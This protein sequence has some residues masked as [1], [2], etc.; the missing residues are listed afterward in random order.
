MP[1]DNQNVMAHSAV[2][3]QLSDDI[4]SGV[5]KLKRCHGDV[6]FGGLEQTRYVITLHAHIVENRRKTRACMEL[7]ILVDSSVYIDEKN[8][9]LINK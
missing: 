4:H 2:E 8:G 5:A 6:W 3:R 9:G 7:T 1:V